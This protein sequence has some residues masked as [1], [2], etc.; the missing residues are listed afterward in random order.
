MDARAESGPLLSVVIPVF[1]QWP[2]TAACLESLAEHPPE[3]PFEVLVVDNGSEDHTASRCGPLGKGLFREAFTHLRLERNL[4]FG[5][6]CNLGA[7]EARGGLVFF[8][9]NDTLLTPGWQP[10]LTHALEDDAVGAAGPLLLYPAVGPFTDRVQH[11]G[12]AV[13]PQ[14]HFQHLY[15]YFP[16]GHPVA[17]RPRTCQAI[18]GAAL[19]IRRSRFLDMGGFHE[20]YRNG[21]EDLE[22]CLRLGRAGLRVEC[23]PRSVVYHLAG[24]TP[25]RFDADDHNARL[26]KERCGEMLAPDLHLH[27]GRDGYELAL[28]DWLQ[29]ALRLPE[30]RLAVVERHAVRVEGDEAV[31]AW[32]E[33]I[34][35]EPL[36]LRGYSLLALHWEGVGDMDRAVALRRL[37]TLLSREPAAW[38][39]LGDTAGRAGRQDLADQAR[40]ILEWGESRDPAELRETAQFMAGYARDL[41]QERLAA[42]Y[43][44]WLELHPVG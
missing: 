26:L 13:E 28:T 17:R 10:P 12:V 7:R 4:N 44:A 22:L 32:E 25:G 43:D 14:L 35:R 18:T 20:G 34:E 38:R 8:L 1:N 2:L 40:C 30:R 37:E 21:G 23:I 27:A 31:A 11:L 9:N 24:Q 16:A 19:L 41:G 6:A 5:P 3:C 39:R 15:E 33:L 29:P 36:W 42:A